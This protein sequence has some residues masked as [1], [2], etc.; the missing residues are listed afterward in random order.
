[1]KDCTSEAYTDASRIDESAKVRSTTLLD[2]ALGEHSV[3]IAWGER[4]QGLS[5]GAVGIA[6]AIYQDDPHVWR[7]KKI[8][9]A[10]PGPVEEAL[11]Y[12]AELV[13]AGWIE[14]AA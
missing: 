10:S 8:V 6:A 3:G 1:M 5:F 13:R 7:V 2:W 11:G 9:T 14:V 12:L 4:Y